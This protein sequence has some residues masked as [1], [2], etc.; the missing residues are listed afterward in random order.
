[1]KN[2]DPNRDPIEWYNDI[3]YL[4]P[5]ITGD[6]AANSLLHRALLLSRHPLPGARAPTLTSWV[7]TIHFQ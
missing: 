3:P 1:M 7:T 2:G 4:E 5:S 6:H